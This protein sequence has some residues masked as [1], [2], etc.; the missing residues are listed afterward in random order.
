VDPYRSPPTAPQFICVVCYRSL[1]VHAGECAACG[2]DRLPLADPEVR[3]DVRAEAE[4]RLQN[5]HYGEWFWLYLVSWLMTA[6]PVFFLVHSPVARFVV[7]IATTLLLG[8]ANVKLY[9]RLNARSVLRLY[10]DR[11]RRH[12]LEAAGAAPKALPARADDPED[13]D[14]PHV[15]KLL[16][17]RV[18][19]K[20]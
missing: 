5:R 9:E 12:A 10:A 17:A 16:G 15:L 11:R 13:A 4:R 2:V 7:W 14:L 18:D 6:M 8:G 20:Q 19:E 1:S 3:A